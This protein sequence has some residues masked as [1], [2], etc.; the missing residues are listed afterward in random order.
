MGHPLVWGLWDAWDTPELK[1]SGVYGTPG[2][3]ELSGV[4][5]GSVGSR[6][7]PGLGGSVG[8]MCVPEVRDS[9]GFPRPPPPPVFPQAPHLDGE[10]EGQQA[11]AAEIA[12]QGG[13]EGPHQVVPGRRRR[14][15]LLH[16]HGRA[17][18]HVL[19][20][21]LGRQHLVARQWLVHAAVRRRHLRNAR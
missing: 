4:H 11:E 12:V 16:Q 13:E 18:G 3:Q 5:G 21:H 17:P 15:R 14:R 6:G 20:A 2:G 8:S 1:L 10:D 7:H 19:H 9:V